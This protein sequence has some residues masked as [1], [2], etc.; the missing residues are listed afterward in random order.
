MTYVF[1]ETGNDAFFS[2]ITDAFC[3]IVVRSIVDVY[4]KITASQPSDPIA[5]WDRIQKGFDMHIKTL[6]PL[7]CT[8]FPSVFC[9]N[10]ECANNK[11][12][13]T[14]G[15]LEKFEISMTH[16]NHTFFG[17]KNFPGDARTR[18]NIQRI[19]QNCRVINGQSVEHI[20]IEDRQNHNDYLCSY[21]TE[22][23]KLKN[24]AEGFVYVRAKTNSDYDCFMANTELPN[25]MACDRFQQV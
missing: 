6:M 23:N 14:S 17:A 21:I 18:L 2:V 8:L 9:G 24:K 13:L 12:V 3:S 11:I 19:L 7:S 22:T 15:Q 10:Q 16:A 1:F 25:V 5:G 20:P 4:A